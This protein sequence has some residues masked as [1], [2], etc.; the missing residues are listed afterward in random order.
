[1][2]KKPPPATWIPDS[3]VDTNSYPHGWGYDISVSRIINQINSHVHHSYHLEKDTN[4]N[5]KDFTKVRI[6]NPIRISSAGVLTITFNVIGVQR[7]NAD[8]TGNITSK[9]T[10]KTGVVVKFQ[11]PPGTTHTDPGT[12]LTTVCTDHQII[13]TEATWTNTT[14][15]DEY[16]FQVA[17]VDSQLPHRPELSITTLQWY[18][19]ND[20]I[21]LSLTTPEAV[22]GYAAYGFPDV[23]APGSVNYRAYG[24]WLQD[25]DDVAPTSGVYMVHNGVSYATNL[26]LSGNYVSINTHCQ[27][28]F[29]DKRDVSIKTLQEI[30]GSTTKARQNVTPSQTE[31]RFSRF[32]DSAI[33]GVK[34]RIWNDNF[35][36]R[37]NTGDMG[38]LW[39]Q[40]WGGSGGPWRIVVVS[41]GNPFKDD[42]NVFP[43]YGELDESAN[44]L[45]HDNPSIKTFLS[46]DPQQTL[47]SFTFGGFNEI[48]G[49]KHDID[50]SDNTATVINLG[51]PW[52]SLLEK[53]LVVV[54]DKGIEPDWDGE[55]IIKENAFYFPFYVQLGV[56]LRQQD[57]YSD[58]VWLSSKYAFPFMR[59]GGSTGQVPWYD[60]P[61]QGV[62][63][64]SDFVTGW[65]PGNVPSGNEHTKIIHSAN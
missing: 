30:H 62:N 32:T 16:W 7:Q 22:T 6:K 40:P 3:R 52:N 17:S 63:R 35:D 49:L 31:K 60:F 13:T 43:N 15:Y 18:Y 28:N 5:P 65:H 23:V 44:L 61:N 21:P 2:F 12:G 64:Y 54:Y 4:N 48:S 27:T 36:N 1:M 59:P 45:L 11:A 39:I 24:P 41:L 51:G 19:G 58:R 20:H 26:P 33:F 46:L 37:T 14:D 34:M 9:T 25:V 55:S 50:R 56:S 53:F 8:G 29:D 10:L 38:K 47:G 57:G 42:P